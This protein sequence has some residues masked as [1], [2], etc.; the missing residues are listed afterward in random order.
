MLDFHDL[1]YIF[2]CGLPLDYKGYPV[3]TIVKAVGKA[4]SK[5]RSTRDSRL[6]SAVDYVA[7]TSFVFLV[8]S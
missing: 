5:A 2:A 3:W 8:F 1:D 6:H 7:G 4:A